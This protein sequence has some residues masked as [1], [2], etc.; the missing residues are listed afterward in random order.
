MKN[1]YLI[2]TILLMNISWSQDYTTTVYL[3]RHAE[4]ADATADTHLSVVGQE[5]AQKWAAYFAGKNI[6]A[7]Y[8]TPYNRTR[9]T[10]QP[11]AKASNL[12]ITEYDPRQADLKT[13]MEKHR[14]KSIVI[15]GHSNTIP[16][17]INRLLG[18][19]KLTDIPETEFGQLYI[20]KDTKGSVSCEVMK[21]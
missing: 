20:I 1:L 12:Q 21:M 3:M 9:E 15:V 4:K 2:L 18:E 13:L 11:L 17:Y 5:R 14:G 16:G 19:A 8:S 10:V 7:I 6:A